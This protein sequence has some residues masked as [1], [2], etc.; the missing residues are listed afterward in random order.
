M[1]R[2]VTVL[3]LSKLKK[4]NAT[5]PLTDLGDFAI[6]KN[7]AHSLDPGEAPSNSVLTR[8]QTMYNVLKYRKTW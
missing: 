7:V 2:V 4:I 5:A 1:F 3:D 8:V 6:F